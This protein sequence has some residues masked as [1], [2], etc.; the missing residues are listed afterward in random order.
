MKKNVLKFCTGL[1]LLFSLNSC[2]TVFANGSAC[3]SKPNKSIGEPTRQL[4]V[5]PLI[6]DVC[7]GVVPLI[8]DIATGAIYK[9]CA[10]NPRK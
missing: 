1:F 7:T 2:A 10:K 8:I 4:R 3:H 9:P 5:V 6:L